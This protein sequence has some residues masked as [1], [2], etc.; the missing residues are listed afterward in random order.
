MKNAVFLRSFVRAL[1]LAV[2]RCRVE[3]VVISKDES[4]PVLFSQR[5]YLS[6]NVDSLV[7]K[8]ADEQHCVR[9]QLG[10]TSRV[11]LRPLPVHITHTHK[12]QQRI[13]RAVERVILTN[14]LHGIAV[15]AVKLNFRS[16][17]PIP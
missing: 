3:C 8:I 14:A 11:V 1:A 4:N 6:H 12:S 2:T 15:F 5:T 13:R 16:R 10:E 17:F 7:P 9:A